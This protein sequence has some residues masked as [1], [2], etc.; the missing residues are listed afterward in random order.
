MRQFVA[1]AEELHFGRAAIRLGM[2]QPPLSQ[3]IKRL[4]HR[5]GFQV[6]ERS[7]R[8]VELTPAGSVFLKEARNT[9]AQADAAVRLARQAASHE[10]A[11]LHVTFVS[12]ALYRLLPAALRTFR[13]RFPKVEVRLDEQP[14]DTQIEGLRDGS[15]DLG[16]VHPPLKTT[17]GLTV[18]DVAKEPLVAAVPADSRFAGEP[19]V[20][21]ANFKHEPFVLFPH[22]QGP[23]LHLRILDA[24]RAA[25]FTPRISQE[26]GRMHTI[27]SLVA[28]GLGVSLVPDGA[29]TLQIDGMR[30]VPLGPQTD[31]HLDLAMVW[32]RGR[33]QRHVNTFIDTV[34]RTTD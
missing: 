6:L 33:P 19:V 3:A 5:L 1:V 17:D 30:F 25:G 16:F 15:I 4:E 8:R 32:R 23:D 24:C 31:L 13:T 22:V 34:T 11:E 28:C 18:R 29:R 21:L 12:A 26:A 9:L 10:L 14:T 7:R 20:E 27:L 2:A